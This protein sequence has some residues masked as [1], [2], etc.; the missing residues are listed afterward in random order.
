MQWQ[1]FRV[2]YAQTRLRKIPPE[3]ALQPDLA[4][5]VRATRYLCIHTSGTGG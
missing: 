5:D 2:E 4:N 1:D 3:T